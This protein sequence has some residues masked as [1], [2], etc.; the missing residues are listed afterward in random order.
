LDRVDELAVV[1]RMHSKYLALYDTDL[2]DTGIV[3]SEPYVD[4]TF[5]AEMVAAFA[6]DSVPM[7]MSCLFVIK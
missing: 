7:E 1:N 6:V 5:A 2:V 4:Q 3:A